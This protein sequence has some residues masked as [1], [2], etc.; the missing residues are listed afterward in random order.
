M[1]CA[2]FRRRVL[3][4]FLLVVSCAST[5]VAA[6]SSDR[7]FEAG[8]GI[9]V[10][11]TS[12]F[13]ATEVGIAG[14][15]GWKPIPTLGLEVEMTHYPSDY[16][17]GF[18]FSSARWEGFFGGTF[19]PQLGRVRPYVR[20][21]PGFLAYREAPEPFACIAIFPPPLS[22]TLAS[23]KTVFAFDIGGGIEAS[24]SQRSF[25]RVDVGDRALR[26][27]GPVFD[28][29]FRRSVDSF[30]SHGFRFAAGAGLRF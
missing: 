6:Q 21:R 12:A 1:I 17:G 28:A 9:A 2:M 10:A 15:F 4:L 16:P 19:G 5:R 30:W 13:D 14:R 29:D 3:P 27:E 20:V 25:V 22:C 18:A 8:A 26:Y 23:G 11:S 24:V 7:R